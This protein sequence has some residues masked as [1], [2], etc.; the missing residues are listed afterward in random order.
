MKPNVQSEVTHQR[1]GLLRRVSA[2]L[3]FPMTVLSFVWFGLMIVE[4]TGELSHSLD[5]LNYVIWG[6]FV[7]HFALEFSI[8]PH[9]LQ[10]LRRNW[11]TAFALLLPAFRMLRMIRAFRFVRVARMGRGVRLV[12]WLTSLNRGMNATRRSLRR[13]GLGYVLALTL[14]AAFGGAAGIYAF[15]N[16][17]ALREAGYVSPSSP[18]IGIT[19]YGESL[20]WTAMMLTT[21]GSDYF[22]RSTEGR[23]IALLLAVYA[24]AI[25]GYITATVASLIIR[26]DQEDKTE[27]ALVA[28]QQQI[29]ELKAMRG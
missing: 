5:V 10:Y 18:D 17:Q 2:L 27:Q 29:A 9:K 6:L 28:L 4:F 20:W 1:Q 16:P 23:I 19:S 12:R 8:A 7:L 11:L 13:R 26:V 15:E 22:P 3:D 14:L 21:M 25:F 24:F